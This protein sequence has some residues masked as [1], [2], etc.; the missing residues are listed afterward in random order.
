MADLLAD[1]VGMC[2][3]SITVKT[4]IARRN[5]DA[6]KCQTTYSRLWL[7]FGLVACG[8]KI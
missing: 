5:E 1:G 8:N 2:L 7:Q 3:E 6:A 4:S